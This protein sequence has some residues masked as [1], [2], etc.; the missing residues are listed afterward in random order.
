V[1]E[2]LLGVKKGAVNLFS[3][4]NDTG[5]KVKLAID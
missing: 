3:I 4:L 2:S 5:K 1:M